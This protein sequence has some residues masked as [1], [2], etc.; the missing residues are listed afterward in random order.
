MLNEE[1]QG[2]GIDHADFDWMSEWWRP[3]RRTDWRLRPAVEGNPRVG[4]GR[5]MTHPY[6]DPIIYPRVPDETYGFDFD[7]LVNPEGVVTK[8]L[9]GSVFSD[10]EEFPDDVIM[11]EVWLARDMSTLTGFF[12]ELHRYRVTP[13]PP[14]QFIGWQPRDRTWKRYAIQIVGLKLGDDEEFHVE[15]LG[16]RA[17][18]MRKS[19]EI[20]FKTIRD[21]TSAAGGLV[22]SGA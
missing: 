9:E 22:G 14:G 16:P 18:L 11:R 15:E 8:T 3:L 20:R 10:F 13:L 7:V 4:A 19:L 2:L 21:V 17:H 12:R 5:R 6:L 1:E